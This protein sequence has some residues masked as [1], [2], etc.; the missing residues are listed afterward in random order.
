MKVLV[1]GASGF[2]GQHV[3]SELLKRGHSV[4][5]IGRD[6]TKMRKFS[7]FGLVR[8][9]EY[10]IHSPILDPYKKFGRPEAIIHL[11]WSG[12]PNYESL[13]HFEKNL[14]ADYYFLKALV[15]GG[16]RHLLVTG[17]C[18]EYGMQSGA[19]TELNPTMPTNPYALAKDTLRKFLQEFQK[20]HSFI[21]QWSRL[22]Y[23]FG[24]GQN[25]KSLLA[26]LDQAIDKGEDSFNMSGGEQIRDYLPVEVVA[27]RLVLLIENQCVNGII[28]ICSGKPISVLCLVKQH[29]L[30]RKKQIK[31]NLGYYPYPKYEP[32]AFWGK[33]QFFNLK[34]NS[35]ENPK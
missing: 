3:V 13:F 12:L 26:Q 33:T 6:E 27:S 29:L 24:K 18:L 16:A 7:W 20:K 35:Y 14:T 5:T 28:N 2:V 8:F 23:I 4:T 31:L 32:M 34:K 19:L 15:V 22:F 1:T 10:D 25:S 9:I 21:L 17:T 30:K 11:A